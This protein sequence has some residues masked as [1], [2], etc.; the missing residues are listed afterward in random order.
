M[1]KI[2]TCGEQ[3]VN[4]SVIMKFKNAPKGARFN[5]IGD[6]APKD[7]YVKIHAYDKG[8]VV[9]WNGNVEGHQSHCCWV[10]E[11]NGYTFD[12]EILVL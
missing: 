1:A 6:E 10:D 2:F 8:L 4:K 3:E 7:V 11:E 12:T 5:F 9:K